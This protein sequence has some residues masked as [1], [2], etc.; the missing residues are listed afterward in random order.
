ML[1]KNKLLWTGFISLIVLA[2]GIF[3][4]VSLSAV[5]HILMIVP[6]L[7]FFFNFKREKMSASQAALSKLP[8]LHGHSPAAPAAVPTH[9]ALVPGPDSQLATGPVEG[10]RCARRP[11]ASLPRTWP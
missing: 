6:A 5:S 11:P 9:A 3:T 4:S 10:R 1:L 2:L 7:Y 8:A